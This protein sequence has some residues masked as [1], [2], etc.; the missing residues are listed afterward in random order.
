MSAGDALLGEVLSGAWWITAAGAVALWLGL[1]VLLWMLGRLL[2]R[3]VRRLRHRRPKALVSE[4]VPLGAPLRPCQ[5]T[6][7]ATLLI[8][9]ITDRPDAT[10]VL[11]RIPREQMSRGGGGR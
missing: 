3:M 1:A 10:V 8:P 7:A 11:P 2:A 4:Q 6:E 5:Y 9:R